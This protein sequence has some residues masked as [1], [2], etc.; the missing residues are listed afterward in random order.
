MGRSASLLMAAAV[1]AAAQASKCPDPASLRAPKVDA[2]F[3]ISKLPGVYYELAYHDYTQPLPPLCGCERSDKSVLPNGVGGVFV[4]DLFSLRCPAAASGKQQLAQL[5]FNTTAVNGVLTGHWPVVKSIAIPDTI[6]DF[7]ESA[8]GGYEWVLEFQCLQTSSAAE[9][10]AMEGAAAAMGLARASA[11]A[12]SDGVRGGIYFVG[13]NF[14]SRVKSAAVLQ[15]MLAAA[16]ARGLPA[17]WN[18]TFAGNHGGKLHIVNQTACTYPPPA[19]HTAT[20][21]G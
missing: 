20:A 17:Y 18:G 11:E 4:S 8:D 16:E 14:Y 13:I 7:A 9:A 2:S 6:V 1:L 5:T 19:L 21:S 15:R 3:D 12:A 10:D